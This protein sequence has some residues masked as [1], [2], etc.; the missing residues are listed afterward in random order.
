VAPATLAWQVV[1]VP[2]WRI[3]ATSLGFAASD[4]SYYDHWPPD[5]SLHRPMDFLRP[6]I[7]LP[8]AMTTVRQKAR[9]YRALPPQPARAQ[10]SPPGQLPEVMAHYLW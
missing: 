2:R 10:P 8:P 6:C 1:P 5:G 4:F 9:G 3:M 7:S